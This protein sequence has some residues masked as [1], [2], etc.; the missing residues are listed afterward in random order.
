VHV[1]A[2]FENKRVVISGQ[3]FE[4][5]SFKN[6]ELVFDGRPTQLVGN[7]FDG[8]HWTFEGPAAD[9]LAFVSALC[10]DSP[11]FSMMVARNIG[12]VHEQP[13]W[14]NFSISWDHA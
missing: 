12:F 11:Q 8:C 9:T 6:C 4:R 13:N 3:R 5:C 1:Q 10:A 2:H 14:P 7:S